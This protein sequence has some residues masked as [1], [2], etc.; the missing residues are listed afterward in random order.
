M[1]SLDTKQTEKLWESTALSYYGKG[2]TSEHQTMCPGRDWTCHGHIQRLSRNGEIE[3][4]NSKLQPG[5]QEA[6]SEHQTMC[7]PKSIKQTQL[8]MTYEINISPDKITKVLSKESWREQT[9]KFQT[10]RGFQLLCWGAV[11]EYQSM[12]VATKS[13][14]ADITTCDTRKHVISKYKDPLT[15][16]S[17]KPAAGMFSQSCEAFKY[18]AEEAMS[19]GSNNEPTKSTWADITTD[20]I[21]K[22]AHHHI[23]SFTRKGKLE[24]ANS[25]ASTMRG[26]PT[27]KL[28]S[29]VREPNHVT[30][31]KHMSRH[32]CTWHN[33]T[34]H[35]Q[36]QSFSQRHCGKK[37]RRANLKSLTQPLLELPSC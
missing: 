9:Q 5:V 36:I 28:K 8:R 4:A 7:P 21:R 29:H 27:I 31:K 23:R 2:A 30:T 16:G 13:T 1:P 34:C 22:H 15:K 32:N 26:F 11:S 35:R 12:Y 37:L 33:Q 25:K 3:R 10:S 14:L 24:R 18:Y 17:F 6:I 19:E 20:D